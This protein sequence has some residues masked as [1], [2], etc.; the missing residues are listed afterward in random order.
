MLRLCS[1][2][3]TL[4]IKRKNKGILVYYLSVLNASKRAICYLNGPHYHHYHHSLDFIKFSKALIWFTKFIKLNS[5][6]SSTSCKAQQYATVIL[7]TNIELTPVLDGSHGDRRRSHAVLL[8]SIRDNSVLPY[9]SLLW[10]VSL[11]WSHNSH[12]DV[13]WIRERICAQI[14]VVSHSN[15]VHVLR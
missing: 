1:N 5:L 11:I 7:Y 6:S 9:C 12:L 2:T 4:I 8:Q 3:L 10:I 15:C 14:I 13:Y